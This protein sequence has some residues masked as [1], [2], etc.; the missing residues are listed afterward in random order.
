[1]NGLDICVLFVLAIHI[2][3]SFII[4]LLYSAFDMLL[5][6]KTDYINYK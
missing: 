1:V 4:R 5:Q 3:K 6:A 2:V